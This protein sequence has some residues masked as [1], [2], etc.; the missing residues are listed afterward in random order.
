MM[1]H[2][3]LETNY[4]SYHCGSSFAGFHSVHSFS[5]P[6]CFSSFII[7]IIVIERPFSIF[8]PLSP[9]S[10][11]IRESLVACLGWL[12]AIIIILVKYFR[13]IFAGSTRCLQIL[14]YNFSRPLQFNLRIR[15]LQSVSFEASIAYSELLP[16]G[17]IA[18]SDFHRFPD[19][20]CYCDSAVLAY[21]K[22]I[23]RCCS[24][25]ATSKVIIALSDADVSAAFSEY[26]EY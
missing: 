16:C 6:V 22:T 14:S 9:R 15:R 20:T 1:E 17:S 13:W 2:D 7:V 26:C 5:T 18:E 19:A 3:S 12:P 24:S 8:A 21:W 25:G 4:F 23:D 11:E 10:S